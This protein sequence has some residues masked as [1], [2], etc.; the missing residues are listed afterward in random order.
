M[1][2][3]GPRTERLRVGG[4]APEP[5]LQPT[6]LLLTSALGRGRWDG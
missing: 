3:L 6:L 2:C 5:K 4:G 1:W